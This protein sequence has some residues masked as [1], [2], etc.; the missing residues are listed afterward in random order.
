MGAAVIILS[1]TTGI[2]TAIII[3]KY[4]LLYRRE[5]ERNLKLSMELEKERGK[6][7]VLQCWANR[8]VVFIKEL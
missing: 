6:Y 2:V 5:Q 4:I 7:M 8:L 3:R 1:V